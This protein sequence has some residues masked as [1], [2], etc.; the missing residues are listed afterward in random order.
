VVAPLQTSPATHD[1]PFK[2][3]SAPDDADF[4]VVNFDLIDN[5]AEIGTFSVRDIIEL[6]LINAGGA[7]DWGRYAV[8]VAALPPVTADWQRPHSKAAQPAARARW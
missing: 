8:I 2:N 4:C 7:W 1:K 5:R 6:R 3:A